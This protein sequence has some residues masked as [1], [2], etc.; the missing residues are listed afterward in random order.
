VT[1]SVDI[2]PLSSDHDRASFSCGVEALDRYLRSQA[3]QDIRRH[4]SNCF[5]ASPVNTNGVAGYYTLSATSVPLTELPQDQS[6]RLPR[7]QAVPA[8]LVGRLAVD[9]RY[10]GTGLGSILLSDALQRAARLDATAFA[11]V[12]DAIDDAAV[13][14]YRHNGFHPFASRPASL[15]LPIA[16]GVKRIGR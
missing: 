14:F 8:A 6:Q 7:Y 1:L 3:G 15:F 9:L 16:T 10:R 5:V 11:L 12:V 2:A 13:A 4:V